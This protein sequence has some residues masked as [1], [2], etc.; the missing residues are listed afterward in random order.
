MRVEAGV[1]EALAFVLAEEAAVAQ[2]YVVDLIA[3]ALAV[4]PMPFF[5]GLLT[6]PT[7]H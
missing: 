1:S 4:Q 7:K 5:G 3:G 2:H 6:F